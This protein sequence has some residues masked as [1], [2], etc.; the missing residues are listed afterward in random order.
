MAASTA[1]VSQATAGSTA[2]R[3][4]L[5]RS[6][7]GSLARCRAHAGLVWTDGP[8]FTG[9]TFT[10]FGS[11]GVTAVC[12]IVAPDV[13][14]SSFSGET[15]EDRFFGCSDAGGI[16]RVQLVNAL[17]GGIEADHV[18]DGRAVADTV[19]RTARRA[20]APRRRPGPRPPA[21]RRPRLG[22]FLQESAS[23]AMQFTAWRPAFA[24]PLHEVAV[25]EPYA[26][27][28][29]ASRSRSQAPAAS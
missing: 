10:A 3:T 21:A 26:R 7:L 13:A 29:L 9:V 27:V 6:T 24:L 12:T 4:W 20:R 28:S 1:A 23:S 11:D 5:S 16:S 25:G 14:N 2:A 15:A 22:A 18:Q 8:F 17:G 19:S